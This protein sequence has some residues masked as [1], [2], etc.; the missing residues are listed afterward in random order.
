M[1]F[2]QTPVG[3]QRTR[4][5]FGGLINGIRS[6]SIR[7][8]GP[9]GA[10]WPFSNILFRPGTDLFICNA[11]VHSILRGETPCS[12]KNLPPASSEPHRAQDSDHFTFQICNFFFDQRENSVLGQ[13][14]LA[15][16]DTERRGDFFDRPLLNHVEIK[17]L[18]LPG[19]NAVFYFLN[20]GSENMIS[21]FVLPDDLQVRSRRV[22]NSFHCRC[23]CRGLVFAPDRS[24]FAPPL[25]KLV[26]NPPLGR[27]QQ[28]AF[29]RTNLRVVL[30][31]LNLFG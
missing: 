8:P 7:K 1:T 14:D 23:P 20:C 4:P 10:F 27:M 5:V 19:V 31:P 21:P 30:E 11:S 2:P 18:V 13:I 17:N 25:A 16:T 12:F 3:S 26:A 29:K 24:R 15:W 9:G 28:P 22:R 6:H